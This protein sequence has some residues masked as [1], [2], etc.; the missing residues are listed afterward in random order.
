MTTIRKATLADQAKTIALLKQFPPDPELPNIDWDDAA[1]AFASLAEGRGG[2][3][4]VAEEA[5]DIVGVVTLG[6]SYVLRFGGSY[7]MIE[8]FIV[9]EKM[10]GKGLASQL[11][12]T[13]I[14]E[15]RRMG[16]PELQV[17]GPSLLG[18]PVYLRN[19]FHEAGL[20][21]KIQL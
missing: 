17:N 6:Y 4:F 15:A 19:G 8:E 2:A 13:A 11:I 7:A 14:E 16:C 5:G 18:R 21:M 20:H 3:I 1:K 9:S 10:R 12:Q